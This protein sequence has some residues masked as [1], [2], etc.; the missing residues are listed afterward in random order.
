MDLYGWLPPMQEIS[1]I[2]WLRA[3]KNHH[4]SPEAGILHQTLYSSEGG[5]EPMLPNTLGLEV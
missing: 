1:E 4:G 5:E 3:G 2:T